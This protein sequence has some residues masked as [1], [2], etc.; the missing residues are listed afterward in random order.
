[1]T[2][3]RTGLTIS[4]CLFSFL[5]IILFY[6][7]H[8]CWLNVLNIIYNICL[9]C[10]VLEHRLEHRKTNVPEFQ[11]GRRELR[12]EVGRILSK[13]GSSGSGGVG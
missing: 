9:L 13:G 12:A 3:H 4:L 5:S 2:L 6:Y 1:V 10:P 11:E 8:D 7:D